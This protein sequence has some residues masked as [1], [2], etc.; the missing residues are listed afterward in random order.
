[1]PLTCGCS[2]VELK[3]CPPYA[4]LETVRQLTEDLCDKN[5]YGEVDILVD[6]A[7]FMEEI[8]A[9]SCCQAVMVKRG[10]CLFISLD[11]GESWQQFCNEDYSFKGTSSVDQTILSGASAFLIFED[12]SWDTH[13]FK[14]SNTRFTIPTSGYYMVSANLRIDCDGTHHR[15]RVRTLVNGNT[16]NG[17]LNDIDALA[18]VPLGSVFTSSVYYLNSGDYIEMYASAVDNDFT[19]IVIGD[20]NS[21]F[22]LIHKI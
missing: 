6:E 13:S 15:V 21:N 17:N 12:V 22:I 2:S 14:T 5:C 1:M 16:V 9:T 7:D 19:K 10:D 20:S 18:S 3:S 4:S 8:G 11:G